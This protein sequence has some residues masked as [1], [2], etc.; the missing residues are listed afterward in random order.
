MT[1]T[2]MAAAATSG[3]AAHVWSHDETLTADEVMDVVYKTAVPLKRLSN[4]QFGTKPFLQ[5]RIDAC[6]AIKS[7]CKTN[8]PKCTPRPAGQDDSVDFNAVM[9]VEFPTLVGGGR[10]AGHGAKPPGSVWQP[11]GPMPWVGPQPPEVLCP[12]CGIIVSNL[13]GMIDVSGGGGGGYDVM[14]A[15]LRPVCVTPCPDV[16]LTGLAIGTEFFIDISTVIP[17]IN[18]LQAAFLEVS[19]IDTATG[20]QS[21]HLSEIPIEP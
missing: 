7:V 4:F 8:C 17:N 9:A 3:L 19:L 14:H 20:E 5:R 10:T 21:M 16:E 1:G 2:S 15:L 11:P 6:A 13:M 12:K 18:E